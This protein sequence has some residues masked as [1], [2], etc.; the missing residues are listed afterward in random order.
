MNSFRKWLNKP[1]RD[2]P[3]VFARFYYADEELTLVAT[4]LDS[5]DGRRD[6]ERCSTLVNQL[7]ACQDKLLRVLQG[8]IV[9]MVLTASE[10]TARDFR[11]KYPDDVVQENLPG[12]LWFGA[13]CLA[14]GSSILNREVESNFMRPLA[15]ALMK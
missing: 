4:E 5:F 2:D 10:L 6:P 8:E 14:A 1:K 3:S 9:P 12:Q 15:R 11:A 7:R 13:E